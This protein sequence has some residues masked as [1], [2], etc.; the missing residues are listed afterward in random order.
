MYPELFNRKGLTLDRLQALVKVADSSSLIE[1]AERDPVLQSQYSRQLRELENFFG[2][3]LTERRS[4]KLVMSAAGHQLAAI[5]RQYL[6]GLDQFRIEHTQRQ[7]PVRLGA[8]DRIIHWCLTAM[9]PPPASSQR[10][11]TLHLDHLRSA[12]IRSR[13]LDHRLD[14]GI[15][16]VS[17]LAPKP[18]KS[19]RLGRLRYALF[20][21]AAFPLGRKSR[22][23]W[24]GMGGPVA[25]LRDAA[26]QHMQQEVLTGLF[27]TPPPLQWTCTSLPAVARLVQQGR[28]AALLP[29]QAANDFDAAAVHHL[30]LPDDAPIHEH[31]ALAWN[32]RMLELTPRI[33]PVLQHISQ[34]LSALLGE[35]VKG[36]A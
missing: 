12:D 1:A 7:V 35:R 17:G 14:I 34:Q 11:I 33:E 9:T 15:V 29:E 32:P 24:S 25:G 5:S 20:I 16:R 21:P 3:A 28:A 30:P 26:R 27:T 13:L 22:G 6:Q 8:G 19:I 4:K 18:L 36:D 2:C 23:R 10:T 31:L